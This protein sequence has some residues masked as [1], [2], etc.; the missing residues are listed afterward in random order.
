MINLEMPFVQVPL[1]EGYF[2]SFNTFFCALLF[3]GLNFLDSFCEK[4]V[5]FKG[6]KISTI[7]LCQFSGIII[8]YAYASSMI[9]INC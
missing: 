6:F 5:K 3:A 2:I 7:H 8:M 1:C 4:L 9:F